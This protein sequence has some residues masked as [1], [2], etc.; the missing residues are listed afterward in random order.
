MLRRNGPVI[1]F[2]E[3]VLRPVDSLWLQE[4]LRIFSNENIQN[5]RKMKRKVAYLSKS[6]DVY[7]SKYVKQKD[8]MV[9][10]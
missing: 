8:R 1:K 9:I 2:V 3:S 7:I 10:R 4:I 6:K 5:L